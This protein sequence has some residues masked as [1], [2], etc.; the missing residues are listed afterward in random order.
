MGRAVSGAVIL[1]QWFSGIAFSL[2]E[3]QVW[4]P[5]YKCEI[6]YHILRL[7]LCNFCML[8]RPNCIIVCSGTLLLNACIVLSL[9][10]LCE[11]KFCRLLIPMS[12]SQCLNCTVRSLYITGTNSLS[13]SWKLNKLCSPF[14]GI[15]LTI[16]N[17]QETGSVGEFLSLTTG[18]LFFWLNWLVSA[19]FISATKTSSA[20]LMSAWESWWRQSWS[21]LT[22]MRLL[23]LR[24][25]WKPKNTATQ[26]ANCF[27]SLISTNSTICSNI[28][29]IIGCALFTLWCNR[30]LI[31][32]MAL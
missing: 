13:A 11:L 9:L 6:M 1:C 27:W 15:L 10:K 20:C 23:F 29:C 16:N 5:I 17:S 14:A 8:Q 3:H 28:C 2:H 18:T 22:G 19:H 4:V 24:K 31:P 26:V 21:R 30:R 32:P 7:L 12:A 25:R